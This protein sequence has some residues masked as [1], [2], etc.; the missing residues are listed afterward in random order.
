LVGTIGF[1]AKLPANLTATLAPS[2]LHLI[3]KYFQTEERVALYSLIGLNVTGEEDSIT[4]T[5]DNA[6]YYASQ[7]GREARFR[8]TVV[9]AYNYAG[10]LTNYR[11]TTID[12]GSIVMRRISI[13][14]PTRATM[15][16]GT[17]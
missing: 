13:S 14:S 3:E 6:V 17:V 7:Q 5:I 4:E 9:A 15:T 11:L 8:L 10:A 16:C 2:F 12:A 1:C